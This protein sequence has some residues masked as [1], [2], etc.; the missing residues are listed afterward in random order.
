MNKN[1]CILRTALLRIAGFSPL[2][3][4]PTQKHGTEITGLETPVL[5]R[6][7]QVFFQVGSSKHFISHYMHIKVCYFIWSSF[8]ENFG[9]VGWRKD[10]CLGPSSRE[11]EGRETN[12]RLGWRKLDSFCLGPNSCWSCYFVVLFA[13]LSI[14]LSTNA[15][16]H[17]SIN[18]IYLSH[19]FML[20]YLSMFYVYIFIQ[21]I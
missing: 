13:C 11:A 6:P 20:I 9:V 19:W 2:P 8:L 21:Y 1:G 12:W 14:C 7:K 16:I 15:S 3:L 4:L 5:A 18:H 10:G 17:L